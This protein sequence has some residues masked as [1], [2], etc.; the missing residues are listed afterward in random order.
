MANCSGSFFENAVRIGAA[1]YVPSE[2]DVLRAREKNTV[3]TE[4]RF[5]MDK[6]WYVCPLESSF[7]PSMLQC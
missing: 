3:I 5:N 6:L 7:I 4:A 2:N 1:E